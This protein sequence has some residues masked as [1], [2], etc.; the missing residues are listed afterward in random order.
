MAASLFTLTVFVGGGIWLSRIPYPFAGE[1]VFIAAIPP[2]EELKTATTAAVEPAATDESSAGL[3]DED[4]AAEVAP[5]P[6][7]ESA[8]A[9]DY[10]R[11]ASIIM[12]AHRPLKPAP[13]DAV[14]EPGPDGALPR[15]SSKGKKPSDVYAQVTP[16]AVLTSGRPKIAILLGGMGLNTRL[17]QKAISEL[18]G[19][20]TFGFAPYGENLQSQVDKARA[21]GHEVLLQLPLEP[22]GYPGNNPGPRTLLT[23]ASVEDNM[24]ALHW[25]MGRFSGFTGITNYLGSRFLAAPEVLK[26]MM[27]ELK[28]RGLVYL[29]DATA[30][31]SMAPA[32]A[33]ETGLPMLRAAIVI[34]ASP[35]AGSIA[36]ALAQ[37]EQE[38]TAN[39]FAIG[40]GTGLEV[41]I[42]TV[43]E[44]AREARERGLLLVPI[45]ATYRGRMG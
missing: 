1:P 31:I 45:S 3:T 35:E 29:E 44:W 40:T 8:S 6:E 30:P 10:S 2:P 15:I 24:A 28:K 42:E 26:P 13:I 20:I 11:E 39:G 37:L 9:P 4:T 19:D 38:A 36:D 5:E 21:K 32:I 23:D 18:P 34:D 22:V 17:T 25:H 43:A 16:T 14:T 12:A 41:T 33:K 7:P 27:L